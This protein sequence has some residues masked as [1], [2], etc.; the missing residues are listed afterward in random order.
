MELRDTSSISFCA[1]YFDSDRNG[2]SMKGSD[3]DHAQDP[4]ELN[5]D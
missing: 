5:E 2:A 4:R 3:D 1:Q